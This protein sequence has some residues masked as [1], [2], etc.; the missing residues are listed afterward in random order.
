MPLRHPLTGEAV[1]LLQVNNRSGSGPPGG[2]PSRPSAHSGASFSSA[3]AATAAAFTQEEQ[4][5]LELAAEQLSELLHGRAEV[6][7]QAAG[8]SSGQPSATPLSTSSLPLSS[9]I[10]VKK[11]FGQGAGDGA[12]IQPHEERRVVMFLFLIDPQ[13]C[14]C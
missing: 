10:A 13:D 1:G 5:I 3:D 14:S 8:S 9:S 4:R 7:L 11:S 2:S 6:F 12:T